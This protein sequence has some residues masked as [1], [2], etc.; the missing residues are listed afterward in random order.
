MGGE[1]WW[2]L[3]LVMLPKPELVDSGHARKEVCDVCTMLV[4][5]LIFV[6]HNCAA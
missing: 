5:D 3:M 2:P 4:P 1:Q 6:G